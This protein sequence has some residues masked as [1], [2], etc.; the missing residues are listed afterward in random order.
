MYSLQTLCRDNHLQIA[1]HLAQEPSTATAWV[2]SVRSLGSTNKYFRALLLEGGWLAP[3]DVCKAKFLHAVRFTCPALRVL[4]L[5]ERFAPQLP[6]PAWKATLDTLPQTMACPKHSALPLMLV[7]RAAKRLLPATKAELK[8]AV[9]NS[10]YA[11]PIDDGTQR[12]SFSKLECEAL[13]RLIADCF[14]VANGGDFNVLLAIGERYFAEDC[15]EVALRLPVGLKALA[16]H[17]LS[18]CLDELANVSLDGAATAKMDILFDIEGLIPRQWDGALVDHTCFPMRSLDQCLRLLLLKASPR[19][20]SD[21]CRRVLKLVI[22]FLDGVP[23][24]KRHWSRLVKACS[25]DELRLFQGLVRL[26]HDYLRTPGI[27]SLY[28]KAVVRSGLITRAELKSPPAL[29]K[30]KSWCM[31]E[32]AI[33]GMLKAYLLQQMQKLTDS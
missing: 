29:E 21:I 33:E 6:L 26:L 1:T 11:L 27:Q 23:K 24:E 4:D 31:L 15:M 32:N 12:W 2:P 18:F 13:K 16:L 17:E 25:T 10:K 20:A 5:A 28:L 19:T 3:A 14:G 30:F 9:A 22:H 7:S 8:E